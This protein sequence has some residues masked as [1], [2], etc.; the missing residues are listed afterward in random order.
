MKNTMESRDQEY[1]YR[2]LIVEDDE[3]IA[4]TL[5]EQFGKWNFDAECVKNFS[6]VDDEFMKYNPQLVIMDISLPNFDG[7][8][9]CEAIRKLSKVPIIFLSSASEN[10]NIVMAL[11][12]GADDFISKPFDF[13]VLIAKVKAVLRRTYDFVG[14]SYILKHGNMILDIGEH[15]VKSDS[16]E[17][18]L[19]KNECRILTI[20][21]E[22]SGNVVTRSEIMKALWESDEFIDE[23]T[24][25]VNINR[26]RKK[27]DEI[28]VSDAVKTKKGEGYILS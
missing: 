20:L 14:S 23:N 7:Y 24:L 8:Y 5:K 18:E 11:S 13:S 16:G 28:G 2:I 25:S 22:N 17:V 26:L 27:L 3:I 10:M 9:W 21:M 19:T 12:A 6:N 4:K 15:V 1:R